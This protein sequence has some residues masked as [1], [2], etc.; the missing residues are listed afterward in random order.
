MV[1]E[2]ILY[3]DSRKIRQRCN[4]T[5]EL[6]IPKHVIKILQSKGIAYLNKKVE[7][8]LVND[9]G[10]LT[11]RIELDAPVKDSAK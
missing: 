11:I 3:L 4:G 5:F 1:S 9:N 7:M 2:E 8:Q 10:K 6:A